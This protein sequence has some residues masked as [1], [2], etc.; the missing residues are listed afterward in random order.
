MKTWNNVDT[1]WPLP[2]P[3][4]DEIRAPAEFT[5]RHENVVRAFLF[6]I[7]AGH[8]P[9]ER[10]VAALANVGRGI[11][12]EVLQLL[13]RDQLIQ[14]VSVTNI[15]RDYVVFIHPKMWEL[16]G[17]TPPKWPGD[18]EKA[19][20]AG[21]AARRC[22]EAA[23]VFFAIFHLLPEPRDVSRQQGVSHECIAHQLK[24]L[25]RVGALPP[26]TANQYKDYERVII[27]VAECL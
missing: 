22:Y 17:V 21:K 8:R 14:K 2:K 27:E 11:Y 6:C 13:D 10:T 3:W 20:L 19:K 9:Y 24:A 5:P 26:S 18:D 16:F 25:R 23:K 12:R 15:S 1:M 4:P 7:R